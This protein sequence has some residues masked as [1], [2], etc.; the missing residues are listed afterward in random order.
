[1]PQ[2]QVCRQLYHPDYV[3]VVDT[4]QGKD[5][6]KCVFCKTLKDEITL[7]ERGTDGKPV[8]KVTKKEANESYLRKLKELSQDEKI[9][10]LLVGDTRPK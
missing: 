10:K 1:M 3:V 6:C 2:C 7:K 5:L 9:S 8:G 4:V